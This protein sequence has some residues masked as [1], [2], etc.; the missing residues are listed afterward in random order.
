MIP[1]LDLKRV[2]SKYEAV[3]Q[4]K[5]KA[6]LDSGYYVLGNEVK[7]F[8]TAFA[9]Y[10]GTDHCIGVGNG[11]DALRLILEGYKQLGRLKENDEVLIA[12]NTYIATVLAVLQAGLKPVWSKPTP[13]ITILISKL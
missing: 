11:L 1:F 12:S 4:S 2:N 6:F 3:F 9:S 7:S 5:F 13:R 10:C 8:E